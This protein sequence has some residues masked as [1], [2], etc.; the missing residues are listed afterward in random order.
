MKKAE[1]RSCISQ[2]LKQIFVR[3]AQMIFYKK[4]LFSLKLLD[5]YSTPPPLPLREDC[6]FILHCP[7]VPPPPLYAI[8]NCG[9]RNLKYQVSSP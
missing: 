6:T 4:K 9:V 5:F 8:K 7:F 2:V 3:H 1:E